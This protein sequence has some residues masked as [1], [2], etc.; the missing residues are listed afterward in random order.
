MVIPYRTQRL[1]KRLGLVVLG[2]VL[3]L[4]VVVICY[5]LV[6][7][8]SITYDRYKGAIYDPN[9]SDDGLKWEVV[10]PTEPDETVP[11][12]FNEGENELNVST[13]LTQM[14]GYYVTAEELETDI[15]AVKSQL[16]QL[17][18]GTAVM[19]DVKSIKGNFFYS[20]QVGTYRNPDLDIAAMDEL[21]QY[22]KISDLYA[23]ARLP[24]LR[25]FN[26]GLNHVS[27]GLPAPGG[28]L[29]MDDDRCYWLNPSSQGTITYLVDIITEL[30]SLGFDEVVFYDFRF[31]DTDGIV[32]K[33]DKTEALTNA[34]QLLVDTCATESF[35]VSFV[36]SPSFPLPD[37]R[38]RLYMEGAEASQAANLAQETG[39][40]DPAVYLVFLT[41]LHDTRFDAYSVMRPLS[42]AH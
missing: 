19:F 1:L 6:A 11:I 5:L 37:G 15:G 39:L 32:F 12:Y 9:H 25:D 22:L 30:R 42:A 35:A 8:R 31:P 34:A 20:S 38:S 7:D 24:A 40:E 41:D 14:V 21:I 29:W 17:E 26:Y 33:Q 13:E 18:S 3:V 16:Q 28:Y 36:G 4:A 27:D 2:L 23:V 10:G